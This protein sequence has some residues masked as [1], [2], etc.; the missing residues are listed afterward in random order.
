[1]V[2][3]YNIPTSTQ[4]TLLYIQA[5]LNALRRLGTQQRKILVLTFVAGFLACFFIGWISAG[6]PIADLL[7]YPVVI[8]VLA[9]FCGT[10]VVFQ[11]RLPHYLKAK[12]VVSNMGQLEALQTYLTADQPKYS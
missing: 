9:L 11:K 4:N 6:R 5:N 10:I 3:I 1:M 7:K 2:R 8:V 12:R